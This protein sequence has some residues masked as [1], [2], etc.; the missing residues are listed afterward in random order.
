MV[1]IDELA[2]ECGITVAGVKWQLQ[3]MQQKNL[4]RRVGSKKGGY[5]EITNT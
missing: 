5:W 1:T 3:Q 4:I 2:E